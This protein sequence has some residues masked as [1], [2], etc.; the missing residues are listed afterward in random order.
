VGPGDLDD[1]VAGE[2]AVV[3]AVD[4][5]HAAFAEAGSHLIASAGQGT[6]DPG[7]AFHAAWYTPRAARE[8]RDSRRPP[9]RVGSPHEGSSRGGAGGE[10]ELMVVSGRRPPSPAEDE[11]TA[12]RV[13]AARRLWVIPVLRPSAEAIRNRGNSALAR[14]LPGARKRSLQQGRL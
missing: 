3:G 5:A 11:L 4:D 7:G 2:V 12:H 9:E 1:D 10:R 6:A 8:Q 14:S 13:S